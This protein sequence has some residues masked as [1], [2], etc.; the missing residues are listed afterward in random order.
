[1]LAEHLK[2]VLPFD[3]FESSEYEGIQNTLLISIPSAKGKDGLALLHE[4]K[5]YNFAINGCMGMWTQENKLWVV[6]SCA[7]HMR[8]LVFEPGQATK[9]I[10]SCALGDVHDVRIIGEELYV[11]ST[12]TN[13]IVTMDHCG[14]ILKRW[15]LPGYGDSWH[16]N[17]IDVWDGKLVASSFGKFTTYRGYKGKMV[18]AGIV[19]DLDTKEV[20]HSGF[21]APHTPRRDEEG[22]VYVCNSKMERLNYS[23]NGEEK[24]VC[25]P[26]GFTRGLDFSQDEIYVGLSS[27]RHRADLKSSEKAI[28]NAQVAILDKKSLQIKRTIT[29]PQTEIYEVLVLHD[30]KQ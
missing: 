12:M 9:T 21:S 30:K 18:E 4:G 5:L 20:L 23:K 27:L 10:V 15:T 26:G 2:K 29:L 19:F 24:E 11:V 6:A 16:V 14:R 22:G 13:E 3:K 8:L 28:N 25:F 17:C 7:D 1:M